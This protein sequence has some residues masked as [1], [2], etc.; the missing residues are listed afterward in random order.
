MAQSRF[1]SATAVPTALTSNITNANT[2]IQVAAATGF[3][4]STPFIIAIDYGTPSEEVCLV[5]AVAGTTFT[6]TRG[7]DGTSATA[8]NVAAPVRHTWTA[9]DGNDSRF[10]EGSSQ[11]VHGI[12][13]TSFVVGTG[14]TQTLTNKT[15][16]SPIIN[17][18]VNI[19]N[20]NITGTVTGGASY[21][22]PTITG[23]VPGGA[24]YLFPVF[25]ADIDANP[26]SVAQKRS[27]T[28]TGA[29]TSWRN[30][31]GTEL[32]RVDAAGLAH[33]LNG[34]KAGS[35]DQLSI[36][37]SGKISS[38]TMA[39]TTVANS[40]SATT[41]STSYVDSTVLLSTTTTVPPSG[42][43]FVCGNTSLYSNTS[44]QTAYA[45]INVVGSVSGLLRDSIDANALTTVNFNTGDNN[46]VPGCSTFIVT[47]ANPGETLTIKWQHRVS[48]GGAEFTN[49]NLVAF[50][51]LG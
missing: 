46:V 5:T 51:L 32:S 29:L 1:Y 44:A 12:A 49:R 9:M 4:P 38:T 50:P 35:S 2:T 3:P 33:W 16:T 28:Q 19:I 39:S 42:K 40:S 36:D 24:T 7:Y 23:T 37:G 43:V 8:H 14:D 13:P 45:V 30:D 47:S 34:M 26:S 11:G 20:P 31:T 25:K 41:T 21:T 15:L 17:G 48:G 10:H 6:V 22:S 27:A 18:T